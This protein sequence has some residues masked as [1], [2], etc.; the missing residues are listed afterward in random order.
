MDEGQL[1]QF[2]CFARQTTQFLGLV[3]KYK[4]DPEKK[5]A[6]ILDEFSKTYTGKGDWKLE[7]R[8]F[9]NQYIFIMT[10]YVEIVLIKENC[11]DKL[12]KIKTNELVPRWGINELNPTHDLKDFLRRMRNAVGHGYIEVSEKLEFTFWDKKP[13]AEVSDFNIT[14]TERQIRNFSQALS[15]W[16]ITGDLDLKDLGLKKL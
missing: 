9:L 4:N 7:T 13:K 1:N 10:L 11:Y 8:P 15:Y 12:P 6:D 16:S 2:I 5:L 14:L 3:D